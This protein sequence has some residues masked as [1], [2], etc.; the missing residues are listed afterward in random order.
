MCNIIIIIK[1]ISRAPIY[2][3]VFLSLAACRKIGNKIKIFVF[4]LLHCRPM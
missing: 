1:M 2:L 4:N 3:T